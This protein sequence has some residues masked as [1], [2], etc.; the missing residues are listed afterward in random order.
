MEE[1]KKGILNE[2]WLAFW[3]AIVLVVVS[4]LSYAEIDVFGWV[5]RVS[6]WLDFDK[7]LAPVGKAY[8]GVVSGGL[9]LV[10]TYLFLTVVLAIGVYLLGGDVKRFVIGFFFV[11]WLSMIC[12]IIGHYA[13]LASTDPAKHN[14][15]WSL[16]L[17]GEG[18]FILALILG[19]ILGNFFRG[20]VAFIQEALKPEFYIKTAIGLMGAVIG[21]KSATAL[22]LASA[23]FF[24]GLCAIVE[25]YLIY[26]G[27]VY[28][29]AR[30]WFKFSREWAAPLAAGISICGVS[31]AIAAGGAIRA[32]P[33]V[34]IMVASLVVI[35]AVVELIILPWLARAFLW[36]EP[37]VAGAWMGLA[38]KTDG[39]AFAAGGITDALIRGKAEAVAG[40]KYEPGWILMAA[41][42]TKLFID[43]FISIW[44]FLLAYVWCAYI[45]CKPGEKTS[46]AEIWRRFP[47]FVLAYALGFAVF[48]II[49]APH[50]PK[51]KGVEDQVK[52][53]ENKI[54]LLE[55]QANGT[56]DV[57]LKEKLMKEIA[58][59]KENIKALKEGVKDS[60]KVVAQTKTATD[61]LDAL[62]V[63]FFLITFF[64]IG[65]I[66]DFRKLW[67]EGIG[68]LAVVY[69]VALFG[70]IIWIGLII[71]YIF[72]KGV[73][74]PIIQ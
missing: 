48:L 12:W 46:W 45:E 21:L 35:F 62:R 53:I 61:G 26:W 39:A 49:S 63:L 22:G 52:L 17:T 4:M 37:M 24:R 74:P 60:A 58:A 73:K 57:A 34:P 23:V 51:V 8:K 14:I 40:I 7:A 72:F 20:F 41:A 69:F 18:G 1:K 71:S 44:A 66:S 36:Q 32:R 25:A 9:S 64:S 68:R 27:L 5:I 67:A 56:T 30:R 70:F 65:A 33:V 28:F 10:L 13:Y 29:I 31:A 3:L 43:I 55:K 15:P 16:K 6:E 50:A 54:K 11:Y 47:K 59:Q 2:D 38:V 42:T 19:L